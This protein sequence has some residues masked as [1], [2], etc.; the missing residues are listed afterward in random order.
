MHGLRIEHL[1][2]KDGRPISI[3]LARHLP[4]ENYGKIVVVTDKPLSTLSAVR[5]QWLKLIRRM[6]I[7]RARSLNKEANLRLSNQILYMQDLRFTAKPPE[8]LLEADVTFS[9]VESLLRA[10]P[11]CHFM[12]ITY[13]FPREKLHMI[14]SWM[15]PSGVVFIYAGR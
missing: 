10:A 13:D 9:N 5:K 2:L 7:E 15:P 8:D 6:L 3:E 11:V 4:R 12:Y 1:P 14:T